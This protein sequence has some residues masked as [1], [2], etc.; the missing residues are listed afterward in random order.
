MMDANLMKPPFTPYAIGDL[1]G[2]HD[3][4]SRLLPQLPAQAPLWLVGDLVNRGP[5]SLA[6]LRHLQTLGQDG[7]VRAVLGNHDLH[8]LA[9]AAGVRTSKVGDTLDDVLGAPDRDALIDW[10]RSQPLAHAQD[11]FLMVHAGVLPQ[12][13][14]ETVLEL[15]SE[16]E[17]GLRG[18]K[19]QKYLAELF[20]ERPGA[21][22][23]S[24]KGVDRQRV[25][26]SALTRLRFCNAAG[27]MDFKFTGAPTEIPPGYLPW[28]DQPAR[29]TADV[30]MVFG[31]WAAA[32]LILRDN[33][34]GLDTGCVWG[35]RLTALP[36]TAEPAGRIPVQVECPKT[37]LL[38]V[39]VNGP[40][41]GKQSTV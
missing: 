8:L 34:C 24:L 35:N 4:F 27:Q 21:W 10:L 16:I 29:K 7:R 40:K 31:H 19:W 1:Q 9:V 30:T 6:T 38:E 20:A 12:W 41:S 26:L 22:N 2:C 14:V 15:A 25:V 5:H 23:R 33:L 36:L 3:A 32:G 17:L 39:P 28:F 37:A 18:A 13:E 11:G